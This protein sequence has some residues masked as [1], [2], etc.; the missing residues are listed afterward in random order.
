M[1]KS[2]LT[3]GSRI[4]DAI[5]IG[6]GGIGSAAVY[7][8]ASRNLRVLGIEQFFP[9]HDLGSSHGSS[10]IIRQAYFESPE[11]VPLVRSSFLLW[12]KLQKE[13]RECLITLN[14]GLIIGDE[15]SSIL[16]GAIRS[17][18]KY[19]LPIELLDSAEVKRRFPALHPR[20][21]DM[22]AFEIRAGYVRPE[23]AIQAHL[24]QAAKLQ[25]QLHF[26]E[27]VHSWTA[28]QGGDGITVTTS[29]A[30]YEASR[31]ILAPGAWASEFLKLSVPLTVLRHVMAWV[32]P[33][34]T[35]ALF[36]P[37]RLPVFIWD[38]NGIDCFYGFPCIPG[39]VPGAKVAMH[40]GGQICKSST[41]NR[42]ITPHD[43]EELREYLAILTPQLSGPLVKAVACMYTMTPDQNFV[44][45]VHPGFRQVS[46]A[47]GFSGH[48]FKF[49]PVMGEI[50]ADLAMN[51][52]TS[53]PI[54]FLSPERFD[55]VRTI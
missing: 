54:A 12:E 8:L 27:I 1:E 46:I 23:A 5:V 17:A 30:T 9:A 7:H 22:A 19:D 33:G 51:G 38:V 10:R 29:R 14:G 53:H 40:S 24:N 11:Y 32:D 20:S 43:I 26:D 49:A 6:L 31:L 21:S 25:G 52:Q 15:S 44:V 50:L 39:D 36:L 28:H 4:F 45:G 55:A 18:T 37:E 13:T 16:Q 48:G 41:I 47:A 35:R 34:Q 42:D 3:G 2:G